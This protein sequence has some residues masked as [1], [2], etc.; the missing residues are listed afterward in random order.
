LAGEFSAV[1]D[2]NWSND[3]AESA[4]TL[5]NLISNAGIYA[6]S[7]FAVAALPFLL[8]PFL[9]SSLTPSEY[10]AV[11]VFSVI[12]SLSTVLASMNL[13]GAIL[14]RYHQSK[15]CSNQ[16][17]VLTCL[18][19]ASIGAIL[20]FL[21]SWIASPLFAAWFELDAIWMQLASA[22]AWAQVLVLITLTVMQ[23]SDKPIIYGAVR[24]SQAATEAAFSIVL[25]LALINSWQG[26][27][28]AIFIASIITACGCLWYLKINGWL[29]GKY[30][31]AAALDALKYGLP[32]VPH[33]LGGLLLGLADR[34]IV[35]K[36]LDLER[37][38]IYFL[39]VQVG[40]V[41]GISADAFNRAFA[42]WLM[43]TLSKNKMHDK[44]TIVKYTYGYFA[45]ILAAAAIA[46]VVLPLALSELIN[47][48][49]KQS[50]SIAGWMLLG[51]AFTGMYYM[52]ANY[53]LYSGHTGRMS[54]LTISIGI[55]NLFFTLFMLQRFGLE[56]A[57]IAYFVGQCSLFI[58]TWL[59][60]YHCY[61][62][63]WNPYRWARSTR[64]NNTH[65]D[66]P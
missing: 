22:T 61:P 4:L 10:G 42:P 39:A 44:V 43:R 29:V 49:Y 59:L 60:S 52:V 21:M 37:A 11:S 53:V 64:S 58:G 23:A 26:R 57:A 46:T 12:V 54:A 18:L 38:G 27:P 16:V 9:T 50:A 14:V 20:V 5:R 48:S 3:R 28:Y 30:E 24:I 6:A 1:F 62:M 25:V 35:A 51:N 13:H 66:N 36:E 31:R 33:A 19:L 40:L 63:P 34:L 41:I 2:R 15:S 45:L 7:N 8:I 17:Y 32:L 56:G 65:G 55:A 47:A